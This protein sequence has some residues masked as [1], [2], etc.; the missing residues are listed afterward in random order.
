MKKIKCP[1]LIICFFLLVA[2]HN[3][4]AQRSGKLAAI[5]QLIEKRNALYF[6]LYTKN[7]PHIVDLYTENA[8]LLAP[9]AAAICG[10]AALARDFSDTYAAGKIRGVQFTTRE[11]Y[12]A[13][14]RYVVEEG[15]WQVFDTSGKALDNGKYLKVWEK[16]SG[17][18]KIF[19]DIFNSDHS[20]S[21]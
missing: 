3:V 5:R 10:R 17:G 20:G 1:R 19:R 11:V 15:G 21:M 12:G 18:W 4:Q 14:S 2:V 16:T 7:D 9:G 8:C 6:E 13:G